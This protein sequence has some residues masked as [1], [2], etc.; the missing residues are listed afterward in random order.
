MSKPQLSSAKPRA[1]EEKSWQQTKSENTRFAI[2]EAAIQ[3]FYD[4]G[5]NNTTTEKIAKQAGVSRGAML[6]HFPSRMELIKAAV[7]HLHKQRL[8]L[9]EE[10]ETKIQ[11]NAEHSLIEEGIDAY[12]EQLHS[13]VFVVFH[14]LRVASRTDAELRAVMIPAIR[15]F[16]NAWIK[17]TRSVFPDFALSEEFVTANRLTVYLLEGMAVS[18]ATSGPVPKQMIAWLKSQLRTLFRDVEVIDRKSARRRSKT[19]QESGLE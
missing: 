19:Q 10:Q 4:L 9:F 7:A 14:E 15:E 6:H 12:W 11:Q 8:Q 17:I 13:K 16:D 18:G 5:F 2:L 1:A 3:C